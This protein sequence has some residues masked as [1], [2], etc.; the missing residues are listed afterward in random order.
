MKPKSN[1]YFDKKKKKQLMK[2]QSSSTTK[3]SI[4]R[5]SGALVLKG[6]FIYFVAELKLTSSLRLSSLSYA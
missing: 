5:S 6:W 4:T 2:S 1:Y 3:L